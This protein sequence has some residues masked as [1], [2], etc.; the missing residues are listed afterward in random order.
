MRMFLIVL[1]MFMAGCTFKNGQHG[2]RSEA[3]AINQTVISEESR[4]MTTGIVDTLSVAPTNSHVGLA[5]D[6]AKQDQLLEGLPVTRLDI[7]GLLAN[8]KMAWDDLKGRYQSQN[9]LL[10]EKIALEAKL[11]ESEAKLI[12]FGKVY[13]AERNTGI[14]KRSW[15]WLLGTV[16]VGGVIALVIFCPALLPVLG[17]LLGFVVGKLPWLAGLF[18]VVSKK[19]FDGVVIG[20]ERFRDS[21][22]DSTAKQILDTELTKATDESHRQAITARKMALAI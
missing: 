19:A 6:L 17:N 13:E 16:G 10:H 2:R 5:L 21:M 14:V 4:V 7:N 12:E 8:Q 3:L 18:G 1:C 20:V 22:K 15:R 11:R 9:T